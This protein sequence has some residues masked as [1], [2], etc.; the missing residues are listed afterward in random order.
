MKYV[1]IMI[2]CSFATGECMPPFKIAEYP[3]T[4]DCLMG[5]YEQSIK[6][7]KRMG[8]ENVNKALISVR[9]SCEQTSIIG[10]P[11]RLDLPTFFGVY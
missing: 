1:L 6:S 11:T 5:G 7:L 10:H 9:L 8:P 4:Y 3:T 2:I